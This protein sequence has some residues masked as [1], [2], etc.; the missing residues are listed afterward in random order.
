MTGKP[1]IHIINIYFKKMGI[2]CLGGVMK[3]KFN[4]VINGDVIYFSNIKYIVRDTPI[5]LKKYMVD[6]CSII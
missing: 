2:I 6:I 5:K 3:K 4:D 1:A